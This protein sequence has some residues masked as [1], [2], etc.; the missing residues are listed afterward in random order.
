MTGA[1]DAARGYAARGVEN[2]TGFALPG[3][4]YGIAVGPFSEADANT[5]LRRLRT[6]GLIPADSYLVDGGRFR[7]QFWPVGVT[8][9]TEAVTVETPG[10]DAAPVE[11]AETAEVVAPEPIPEPDPIQTPDETLREAQ[12]SEQA[13]DRDE[14]RLLQT[15]LQWAGFYDA[16]ID[17]S[18]GRGTRASMRAWQDANNHEATGVLTTGQRA[19]LLQDYNSI[20][21]GMGL[22]LVRDDATGIEMQIPTGV[23]KFAEYEP[24]FARFDPSG[25]VQA[26]VLLISQP[27]DQTR[28][29]GLYEILQT[30]AIIPPEGDRSRRDR[31]FEIEGFDNNVHSYT[32]VVLENGEIKGFTLIW[33]AGDEERRTRLLG[34]M[35]N[36]FTRLEGVLDPAAGTNEQSIDLVA[37]LEIRRPKLA[38]SGFFVDRAGHIVT[39]SEAVAACSSITIE[40]A[41]EAEVLTNDSQTGIAIVKSKEALVPSQVATLTARDPRLQSAL[42]LINHNRRDDH[43]AFDHHLPKRRNAHHDQAVRK[44]ANHK[45]PNDCAPDAPA[46]ARH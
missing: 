21:D 22:Q 31:G 33:P 28:M 3:N 30:L 11:P 19:E 45:G 38:R 10:E 14:K 15:A 17:G 40:D 20:L 12:S 2:V 35:M 9:P 8:A 42:R 7:T 41:F 25:D 32:S 4:W 5:Q 16:A 13:L 1:Q 6:A 37:G 44:D 29:F 18:Y 24:P 27:G 36:S 39:T 26:Q 43:Q 46:P 23:V 34:E